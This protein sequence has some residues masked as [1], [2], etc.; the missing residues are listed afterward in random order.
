METWRDVNG[1]DGSYQISNYGNVKS[2]NGYLF[3]TLYKN[4]KT[5][6]Y[7]IHRLVAEA[8]IPNPNGLPEI[9]HKDENKE[10]NSV[11]NLEWCDRSY[12]MTYNNRHRKVGKKLH[13]RKD[14]SKI[15]CKYDLNNNLIAIYPSASEAARQNSVAASNI[16]QCCKGGF[17]LKGK[18][19]NKNQV[20]GFKY[21]YIT[22]A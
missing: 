18:W 11:E 6:H 14:K 4:G 1:Y 8:F 16:V 12:N 22:L 19:I 7:L 17:T 3:V 2:F 5:K 10:N 20:K 21:S 9:N 13:N 15:V